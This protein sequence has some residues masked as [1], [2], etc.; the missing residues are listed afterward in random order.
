LSGA[1]QKEANQAVDD[2]P[3]P[4]GLPF[5]AADWWRGLLMMGYMT[6]AGG[7]ECLKSLWRVFGGLE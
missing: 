4:K 6:N 2:P 5:P 3:F 1:G 7:E